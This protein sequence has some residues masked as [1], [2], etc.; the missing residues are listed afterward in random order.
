MLVVLLPRDRHRGSNPKT[1]ETPM[2]NP[3]RIHDR[4]RSKGHA[5]RTYTGSPHFNAKPNHATTPPVVGVTR[6]GTS[7]VNRLISHCHIGARLLCEALAKIDLS[8][9]ADPFAKFSVEMERIVG[10]STCVPTGPEDVI[11]YAQRAGRHGLTRFVQNREPLPCSKIQVILKETAVPKTWLLV[12]AFIGNGAEPEPWDRNAT[13]ASESFWR[14]HAL[15]WG[16]EPVAPGTTLDPIPARVEQRIVNSFREH[17]Q[18]LPELLEL[19]PAACCDH[20]DAY[21][22]EP[23]LWVEVDADRFTGFFIARPQ[24]QNKFPR[25]FRVAPLH[26]SLNVV[27]TIVR[28][29]RDALAFQSQRGPAC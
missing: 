6:D 4:N 7:V 14:E 17:W 19:H 20:P 21:S 26:E 16:T 22:L 8:T 3:H 24:P 2:N 9:T 28:I 11:I 1:N 15:V 18:Q 25:A 13:A 23:T 27:P 12:T 5:L 29:H 10:M